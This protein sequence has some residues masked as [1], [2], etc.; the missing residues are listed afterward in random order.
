[1]ASEQNKIS[2]I[3]LQVESGELTAADA[4]RAI[5]E[6]GGADI[7][8]ARIDHSRE[9][10]CGFPEVIYGAGKTIDQLVS[11]SKHF[12][13]RGKNLFIT[14]ISGEAAVAVLGALPDA[15]YDNLARTVTCIFE[16][17]VARNGDVAVVCAGTSDLDVAQEC[18]NSLEFFGFEPRL[19]V[20]VGVAG[21]HRL[22]AR[23]QDIVKADLVIVIAGME[24][25]LP[26][27]VGGMVAAPVIAVPTSVGYGA[28]FNGLAP[29]LGM[30]NSCASGLTVVNI[31]NGFGA[32]CA[33]LR[34][35][36]MLE[37]TT[38]TS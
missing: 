14:R 9:R 33:A 16:Q 2:R 37:N 36:R 17:P 19:V 6:I 10:R 29:L 25:A 32:A 8:C 23:S 26:S 3:L 34:I 38:P 15:R 18:M 20:D 5:E 31:D 28:S 11:I 1:M 4:I 7:G 13:E 12:Q 35:L 30:L 24:G 27:V 21:I 22:M